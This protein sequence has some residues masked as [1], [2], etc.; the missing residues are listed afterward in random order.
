M[1]YSVITAGELVKKLQDKL[2]EL[3]FINPDEPFALHN[4]FLI[5][6]EG[7]LE[8]FLNEEMFLEA[9]MNQEKAEKL[10]ET[11]IFAKYVVEGFT[12]RYNSYEDYVYENT[13]NDTAG[14]GEYIIVKEAYE[15][16][17][18]MFGEAIDYV[19]N[20]TNDEDDC[21]DEE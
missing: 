5:T 19:S 4:E 6:K 11:D 13:Q 16:V 3:S 17:V 14:E 20:N 9:T 7:C 2:N 8:T 21:E 15:D 1:S 10:L 18:D 12:N